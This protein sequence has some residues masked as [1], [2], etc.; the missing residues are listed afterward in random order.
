M[1]WVLRWADISQ[2]SG[3]VTTT[4]TG[5]VKTSTKT[6]VGIAL[7]RYYSKFRSRDDH[8]DR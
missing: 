7:G 3:H 1:K 6:E 8:I 5:S 2:N 4:L